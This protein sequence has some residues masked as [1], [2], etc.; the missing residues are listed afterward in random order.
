MYSSIKYVLDE[1]YHDLDIIRKAEEMSYNFHNYAEGTDGFD[2]YYAQTIESDSRQWAEMR[3]E[4]AYMPYL[5][6]EGWY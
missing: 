4:E 3:V 6:P 1:K 5:H 2:E